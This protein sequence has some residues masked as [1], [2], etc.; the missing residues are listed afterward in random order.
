M[1]TR[2]A[3]LERAKAAF[4]ERGYAATSLELL[5][6]SLGPTRDLPPEEMALVLEKFKYYG[7]QRG[8]ER[9]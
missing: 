1:N 2:E 8:A 6:R 5:A 7:Q 4:A 9:A 3:L